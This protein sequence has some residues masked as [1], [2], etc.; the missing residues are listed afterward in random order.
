MFSFCIRITSIINSNPPI[1][2]LFL[3][4]QSVIRDWTSRIYITHIRTHSCLPGPMT[5]GNEQAN[6]LVSFAAPEE[7]HSLLYNNAGSLNQI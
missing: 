5:H 3:E 2:Q 4:L 1:I 7:Q 6:K